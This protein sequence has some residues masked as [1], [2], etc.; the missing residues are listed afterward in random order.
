MFRHVALCVTYTFILN[1]LSK[2]MNNIYISWSP[3]GLGEITATIL[4][5]LG[6]EETMNNIVA[7]SLTIYYV[8]IH[9]CCIYDTVPLTKTS[10]LMQ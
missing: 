10:D 8:L 9:D 3:L 6:L 5:H 2:F 7:D 1:I 4:G